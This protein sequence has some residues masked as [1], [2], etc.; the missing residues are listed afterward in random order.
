MEPPFF[1]IICTYIFAPL[2]FV[3]QVLVL[4]SPFLWIYHPYQNCSYSLSTGKG[5]HGTEMCQ[6]YNFSAP[7][8]TVVWRFLHNLFCSKSF[9]SI[10]MYFPIIWN[11]C[12]RL[13][14]Y[15]VYCSNNWFKEINYYT[16][17]TSLQ[18]GP[19]SEWYN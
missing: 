17:M 9:L 5:F 1:D 11:F 4:F 3:H 19:Y 13:C 14:H 8:G 16:Y 10:Y 18:S 12:K 7:L 2:S 15:H 6:P